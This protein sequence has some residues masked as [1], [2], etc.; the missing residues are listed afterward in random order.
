MLMWVIFEGPRYTHRQPGCEML[1]GFSLPRV[2][3][4]SADIR[5]PRCA[6]PQN[7]TRGTLRSEPM[8]LCDE[9]H[10]PC[11]E[12]GSRPSLSV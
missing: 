1:E 10:D 7:S 8:F 5:L 2:L 9:R 6:E 3:A 4:E 12:V 11:D